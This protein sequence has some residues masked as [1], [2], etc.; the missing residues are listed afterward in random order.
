[1]LENIDALSNAARSGN[2]IAEDILATAG[3]ALGR[4]IV[5]LVNVLNPELLIF[6]GEG[7]RYGELLLAP[8]RQSLH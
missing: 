2:A 8:L 7:M 3:R 6:S 5:M 1:V 4:G